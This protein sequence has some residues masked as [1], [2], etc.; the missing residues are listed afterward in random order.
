MRLKHVVIT[1]GDGV[2]SIRDNA[3]TTCELKCCRILNLLTLY[4][5]YETAYSAILQYM[6]VKSQ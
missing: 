1:C 6:H 5:M 3:K 4:A 2:S